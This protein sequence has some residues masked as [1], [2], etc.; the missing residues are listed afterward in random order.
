[1]LN[2]HFTLLLTIL[3]IPFLGWTQNSSRLIIDSGHK[4]SIESIVS[5]NSNRTL[6]SADNNGL[7]KIWDLTSDKLVYQVN[8]GLKGTIQLKVHPEKKTVCHTVIPSRLYENS[9]M[10]LGKKPGTVSAEN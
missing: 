4:D 10:G 7:V 8:T 6:I 2:R 5:H 3:M 1:M 9:G